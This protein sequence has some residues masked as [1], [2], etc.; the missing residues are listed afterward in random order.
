MAESVDVDRKGI[1][2]KTLGISCFFHD[3]AVAAMEDGELLYAI[4]EER[5]S[6]KKQDS[7]LPVMAINAALASTGWKIDEVDEIVFY[8][9]PE[10]KLKRLVD[11]V[12]DDWPRSWGLFSQHLRHYYKKRHSVERILREVLRGFKGNVE[13]CEHH[14]SHAA[15]SFYTSLFE[16][17]L[18][19]TVDGVGEY[20]TTAIYHGKG[21][22]LE[23]L[24]SIHF[25]D[26]LGLFYSVFTD[27]LGFEVNSGEYKVMGLAPYGKPVY[28]DRIL[29]HVIKLNE[30]GSFE[31]NR[32]F[33]TF[34][35]KNRH[36]HPSLV[37][38][39]GL[40]PRKS[41][42]PMT[43]EYQDLSASVQDILEDA[44]RN[45]LC[46]W[47]Q[48]VPTKNVC[49]SGGVALNCTANAQMIRDLEIKLHIHPAAGDA[50]GAVGA[51]LDASARRVNGKE[52]Y[53]VMPPAYLGNAYTDKQIESALKINHVD[54]SKPDNIES[55]IATRLADGKIVAIFHGKDEWGP[56]AL[57]N[58]SILANTYPA[59]MKHHL[60]AKIKFREEFRPFA[61]IVM[62]EHFGEYFETLGMDSSPHML[63]TQMAKQP[64]KTPAVVHVNGSSRSQTVS[65][66][67]NSYMYGILREFK[68][69]TGTPVLI[70]TSFNLRGEPIV[71][72]PT[73]ALKTFY[74]SG[75]DCLAIEGFLIEKMEKS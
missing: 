5:L 7:G 24:A 56:R 1:E 10:L 21:N 6:R 36:Y 72:S 64:E 13:F 16:E 35:D 74:A 44:L 60:N 46:H 40:K 53:R 49:M 73:D 30:D 43:Q 38:Q 3:S 41:D 52:L 33:F 61:P 68:A 37:Q 66:K 58:R 4:Q 67:Q 71:G 70:N 17:A 59:E 42:D 25:P 47:L 48:K 23:K 19:L 34:S 69:L 18:V 54:Y 26:S 20:D 27:Y 12:I 15:S 55:E 51:A 32:E 14:R 45:I 39:I 2:M 22:K 57:G 65:E 11:Q 8:E 50:G 75:I 63:Y 29:N 28:K 9:K 62:E 31:L